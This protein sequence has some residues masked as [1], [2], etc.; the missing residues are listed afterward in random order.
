V[1]RAFFVDDEPLVLESFMLRPA[2]LECGFV[3]IGHSVNPLEAAKA[4]MEKRPE[5]VFTD[6]K[7]PGLSGVELMEELKRNGFAG[8]F[9]IVSAYR[10]FEETRRFF[11]MDGFDYLIKPVSEQDLLALLEKLSCRLADRKMV[12]SP[13][14]ETP[15]P[16]LNNITAYL[17]EHV[18]EKHSLES[19]GKRFHLKPNFICNLFSRH[20]GT[21]FTSY[22]TS[23][24][25]E[26]AALLLKTTQKTVKEIAVLCGYSDYFYFC[27]VFREMYGCTPTAFREASR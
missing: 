24:R 22:L 1:F 23:I 25:M 2:F 21:T 4:I 16:E 3:N 5:V 17:N 6:L 12:S 13:A 9:V 26:D 18:A 7:M 14:K 20:L 11:K 8:D 19:I 10:E 15:S 27:R